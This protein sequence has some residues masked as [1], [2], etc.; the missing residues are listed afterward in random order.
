MEETR[1]FAA[2]ASTDLD[3]LPA[4]PCSWIRF[5]IVIFVIT[6]VCSAFVFLPVLDWIIASSVWLKQQ[7]SI[8]IIC[9][10]LA[11]TLWIVVCLPSTPLALLSAFTFG[12]GWG[13]VLQA[14][15]KL[16]G[17]AGSFF[18]AKKLC[19]NITHRHVFQ[20]HRLLEALEGA[21]S[22]RG[23]RAIFMIQIAYIPLG[24]RNYSLS[25][26]GVPFHLFITTHV[27]AELP[28]GLAFAFTGAQARSLA[29]LIKGEEKANSAQIAALALGLCG[30]LVAL[31]SVVYYVN[32][33]LKVMNTPDIITEGDSLGDNPGS[34]CTTNTEE[35]SSP[36]CN[37]TISEGPILQVSEVMV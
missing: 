36:H 28:Y 31:A 23:F 5:T 8:G 29:A 26:M 6:G 27:L 3:P 2:V 9:F 11:G 17:S 24:V 10:L 12:F 15:I 34:H 22:K 7:Q 32:R 35:A 19:R 13:F 25:V 4:S 37:G 14:S 1:I 18:I 21:V 33:E 30:V 20:K 16:A